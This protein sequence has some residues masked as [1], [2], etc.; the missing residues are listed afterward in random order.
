M[1]GME[2]YAFAEPF[3]HTVIDQFLPSD[4]ANELLAH[5]PAEAKPHDKNYE[6]GYGGQ[7]KRQ[8]SPYGCDVWMQSAFAFFNSPA[9]L[10]FLEGLTNIKGLIPDPYFAG[11]GLH[12]IST[13]G[14]L[15]IH[16]DFQVNEA[17]QLRRRINVLIY[18]NKDWK[19]EYGGELELWDKTMQQKVKSVAPLFNRCVIFNT[20]C[21]S[22][23]GHPDPLT[24]PPDVTRKSIALY[25]YTAQAIENAVGESRHTLYVARPNDT[26]ENIAQAKKLAA[27]RE[28][29]A[30]KMHAENT[31]GIINKLKKLFGSW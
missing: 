27:K 24:T 30:K 11:G 25:Y 19:P 1:A 13:G 20:D 31:T 23:H 9:M 16:A 10:A 5:F 15:G 4:V 28:K 7:F 29:R 21:D 26:P 6:K 18:L 2:A 22:F 14:M 12:E 3:A 8:I 17:L